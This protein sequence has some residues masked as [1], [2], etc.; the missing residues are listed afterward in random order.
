[1]DVENYKCREVVTLVDQ[2]YVGVDV[3]SI[4]GT[5]KIFDLVLSS[6]DSDYVQQHI[7][8][9]MLCRSLAL[10]KELGFTAAKCAAVSAY[11]ARALEKQG[12]KPLATVVMAD[13]VSP[14]S[15]QKTF[16]NINPVHGHSILFGK[17][18]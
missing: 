15:G 17:K 1:V 5:N 4:L 14:I 18:L 10:A 2:L 7:Y 8:T 6:V 3:F 16:A 11:T 9:E 12:F 13:Y